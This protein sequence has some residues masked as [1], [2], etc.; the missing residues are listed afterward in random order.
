MIIKK[1]NDHTSTT[2]KNFLFIT[3][4]ISKSIPFINR[5]IYSNPK[6]RLLHIST[7]IQES[8]ETLYNYNNQ[9]NLIIAYNLSQYD[10]LSII[11]NLKENKN[12]FFL[13]SFIII[14][15]ESIKIPNEYNSYIKSIS[16]NSDYCTIENNINYISTQKKSFSFN[17]KKKGFI[18]QYLCKNGYNP[19]HLGTLYLLDVIYFLLLNNYKVCPNLSKDIYPI[20]ATKYST[21]S[22]NIKC[23]ITSATKY[24]NNNISSIKNIKKVLNVDNYINT[25]AMINYILIKIAI[26]TN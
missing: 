6:L 15:N 23:S 5:I 11:K 21:T 4:D 22:H 20:I 9:I 25:K 1:S 7:T 14:S 19:S 10:I 13:K 26:I 2:M 17:Q 24:M 8:L 16:K 3:K 18:F 12:T